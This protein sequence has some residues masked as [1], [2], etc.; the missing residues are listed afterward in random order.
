MDRVHPRRARD[1]FDAQGP[2][3]MGAN[4]I[5]RGLHTAARS[6]MEIRRRH[7]APLDEERKTELLGGERQ[8]GVAAAKGAEEGERPGGRNAERHRGPRGPFGGNPRNVGALHLQ[9]EKAD[10][11]VSHPVGVPHLGGAKNRRSGDAGELALAGHLEE[12]SA[13]R[14][15]DRHEAVGVDRNSKPAGVKRFSQPVPV[16]GELADRRAEGGALEAIAI[17][18]LEL[19]AASHARAGRCWQSS[20]RAARRAPCSPP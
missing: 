6:G 18:R 7:A 19:P 15:V 1:F 9:D 4:E 16:G 11:F 8:G 5:G 17:G 13:D 2:P 12:G 20:R 14:E 3:E 10:V